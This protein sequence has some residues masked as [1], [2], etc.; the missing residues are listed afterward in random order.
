LKMLTWRSVTLGLVGAVASIALNGPSSAASPNPD[1]FN[2]YIL[3][4]T[5]SPVSG[6]AADSQIKAADPRLEAIAEAIR[7]SDIET[8]RRATSDL[9]EL[10]EQKG[11]RYAADALVMMFTTGMDFDGRKAILSA[12]SEVRGGWALDDSDH[13]LLPL[14]IWAV[15]GKA[16]GELNDNYTLALNNLNFWIL[17]EASPK[18]R[19]LTE[20]G[21]IRPVGVTKAPLPEASQIKAGDVL[22]AESEQNTRVGPELAYSALGQVK[23]GDCIVVIDAPQHGI[24]TSLSQY[25][26]NWLRARRVTCPNQ[27]GATGR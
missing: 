15:L 22:I 1:G 10:V 6:A 8:R 24:T 16:P 20:N 3:A 18:N 17:Y 9:K 25:T 14:L 19:W 11:D 26:S 4:A 23:K 7:S 12:L 2:S 5:D 27:T 13:S 21:R